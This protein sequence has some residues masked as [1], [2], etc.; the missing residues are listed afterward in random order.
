MAASADRCPQAAVGLRNAMGAVQAG[1]PHLRAGACSQGS[2]R[3]PRLCSK[4]AAQNLH[5]GAQFWDLRMLEA[6]H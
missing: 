6:G 4:T 5:D 2:C 1:H 3:A